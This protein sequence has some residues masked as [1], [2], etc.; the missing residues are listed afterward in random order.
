VRRIVLIGAGGHARVLIEVLRA[1]REKIAGFVSNDPQNDAGEMGEL[2]HLCT[3]EELL[4]AGPEGIDLVN[5]IG[6]TGKSDRRRRLFERF[7]EAGFRFA[8]VMHP[9]AIMASD[10]VLGEGAQV[11][12]G[13]VLQPGVVVGANAIVNTG[14]LVDHDVRLGDHCHVAPGACV[15]GAVTIGEAAHVGAGSTVI[16]SVRVGD[17]AL[18]AAGATVIRDVPAGI[19]VAGVPARAFRAL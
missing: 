7:H 13:A 16:Q 2:P 5:G 11:M 6:S 3:D 14:A 4:A 18:I 17:G 19:V 1:R 8:T 9:A 15:A 12:A 10:V